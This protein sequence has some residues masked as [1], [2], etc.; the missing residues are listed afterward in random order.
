MTIQRLRCPILFR[1]AMAIY[2]AA[3][4]TCFLQGV[5]AQEKDAVLARARAIMNE[6]RDLLNEHDRPGGN[7]FAML[8]RWG[9]LEA[10]AGDPKTAKEWFDM[11]RALIEKNQR[12]YLRSDSL[13]TMQIL[14]PLYAEAGF[15]DE[16]RKILQNLPP[17]DAGNTLS[18]DQARGAVGYASAR[19]LAKVGRFQDAL[20]LIP[21]IPYP[22][23]E[24]IRNTIQRES[25][26]HRARLR[27]WKGAEAGVAAIKD[28]A[29]RVRALAGFVTRVYSPELNL[30][31]QP[32]LAF[33][34]AAAGDHPGALQSIERAQAAAKEIKEPGQAGRA[35][36]E[37]VCALARSGEL[38][39]AQA[40]LDKLPKNA[41]NRSLAVATLVLELAAHDQERLAWQS[42]ASLDKPAERVVTTGYLIAGLGQA[43]KLEA[44]KDAA[45]KGLKQLD[46]LPQNDRRNAAYYLAVGCARAHLYEDALKAAQIWPN[47]ILGPIVYRM[48]K[49]GDY[50]KALDTIDDNLHANEHW[51]TYFEMIAHLQAKNGEDKKALA[52]VRKHPAPEARLYGL[53]GIARGMLERQ[54]ESKGK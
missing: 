49:D 25:V 31:N 16:V 33:L 19:A 50:A 34:Q 39:S 10:R 20:D 47:L 7:D 17:P 29:E 12:K 53:F 5:T 35:G 1:V 54:L 9:V 14:T 38:K 24:E 42:I 44:A 11:A 51:E 28:P 30:P 37:I 18:A 23:P 52:W 41:G 2:L 46:E 22:E 4:G 32:G 40:V 6:A 3:G 26:L 45:A 36:V 21:L 43:G 48:A 8:A 13:N 27:N 15:V